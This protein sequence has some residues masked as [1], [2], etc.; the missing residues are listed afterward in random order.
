MK[1]IIV[2]QVLTD[3]EVERFAE[4]ENMVL[5]MVSYYDNETKLTLM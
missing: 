1:E 5:I 3:D 4:K 2:K